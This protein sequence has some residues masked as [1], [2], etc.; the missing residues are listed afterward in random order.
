MGMLRRARD[1]K[2]QNEDDRQTRRSTRKVK[3]GGMRRALAKEMRMR[4]R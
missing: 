4:L 1:E 2:H 3:S